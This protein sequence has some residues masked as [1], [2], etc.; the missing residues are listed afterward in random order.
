MMLGLGLARMRLSL[1]VRIKLSLREG[2]TMWMYSGLNLMWLLV[3]LH[4]IL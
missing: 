3:N 2:L 4:W 1:G